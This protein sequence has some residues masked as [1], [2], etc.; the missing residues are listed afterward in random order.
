MPYKNKK[1]RTEA[2]RRHRAKKKREE[3]SIEEYDAVEKTICD[4]L[5]EHMGFQSWSFS[6]FVENVQ[7]DF[8][9]KEEGVWSKKLNAFIEEPR[10][11]DGFNTI[12]LVD[13]PHFRIRSSSVSV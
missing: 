3:D 8:V 12:V 4:M 6:R 13:M 5:V 10:L 2:V 11:L 9:V 1:D 7:E